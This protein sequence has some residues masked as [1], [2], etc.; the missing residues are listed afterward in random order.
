MQRETWGSGVGKETDSGGVLREGDYTI[1]YLRRENRRAPFH[2][3]S[4]ERVNS[5]E[6]GVER[7]WLEVVWKS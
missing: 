7:R 3:R 1:T 2:K 5:N 4:F 6:N